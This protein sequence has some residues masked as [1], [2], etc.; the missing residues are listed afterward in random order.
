M[1]QQIIPGAELDLSYFQRL[2]ALLEPGAYE[3]PKYGTFTYAVGSNETKYMVLAWATYIDPNTSARYDVR[4]P[5]DPLPLRGITIKGSQASSTALFLDPALPVYADARDTYYDRLAA[6]ASLPTKHVWDAGTGNNNYS[7]LLPGP[8]GSLLRS[9]MFFDYAWVAL[10]ANGNVGGWPIDYELNDLT[11]TPIR[12]AHTMRLP[13]TKTF[14]TTI[15]TGYPNNANARG[16]I[17]YVILPSTWGVFADPLAPY[18]FRDD[19]M[20]AALDTTTVWARTQS[21]AGNVEI[22]TNFAWL[23]VKGNNSWNANGAFTQQTF[24][25]TNGLVMM[26]D[27]YSPADGGGFCVGWH[28]GAGNHQDDFAHGIV[29]GGDGSTLFIVEN[30]TTRATIGSAQT[31]RQIYRVRLTLGTSGACTYEIQGGPEYDPIGGATWDT[32]APGTTSSATDPLRAGV[33]A[34][35]G[36]Y[37]VGDVR[38]Y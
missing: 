17:T 31:R 20:G 21:T 38:V 2:A 1:P 5:N 4:M 12:F 7:P 28:D 19:F 24:A 10:G 18:D 22:D 32:L 33:A 25:R 8:Y 9:V 14:A 23:K 13:I 3:A 27:V 30:G 35:N 16:T 29:F 34:L 37:Y 6:I 15:I 11:T 36:T 26:A